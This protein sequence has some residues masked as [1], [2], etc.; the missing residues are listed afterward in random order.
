MNKESLETRIVSYTYLYYFGTC[1]TYF[2]V[3]Y[4]FHEHVR[5]TV[6]NCN[7]NAHGI[8]IGA[9]QFWYHQTKEPLKL[10][11]D[12]ICGT[13]TGWKQWNGW[14]VRNL[15]SEIWLLYKKKLWSPLKFQLQYL[16]VIWSKQIVG[17]SVNN[18]DF[19]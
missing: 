10:I 12:L 16:L 18:I 8:E 13:K 2:L 1:S 7:K 3:F 17:H 11:L 9:A 19:Y 14:F 4:T 15:K 6:L 5:N